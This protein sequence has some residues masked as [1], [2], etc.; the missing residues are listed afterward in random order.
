MSDL[1]VYWIWAGLLIAGLLVSWLLTLFQLPGNWLMVVLTA[2]FAGFFP[3]EDG[4]GL[5]WGLVVGT[6][7]LA[8]L[9]EAI[10]AVASAAGAA[11]RGASRRSMGLSVLG[12]FL[13]SLAGAVVGVPI[14]IVGSIIAAV[15]GGALGAFVG[16]WIGE[17][18]EGRRQE[19]RLAIGFAAFVGRLFGTMGKTLTG[20]II[21]VVVVVGLV[22]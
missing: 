4:R 16:A 17:G 10:E 12:A 15:V 21:V 22:A 2:V 6:L 1:V 3:V 18:L 11:R 20:M 9:G 19:E 5:S 13:G 8:G 14:P 7:A